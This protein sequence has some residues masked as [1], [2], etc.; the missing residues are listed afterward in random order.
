MRGRRTT[1]GAAVLALGFLGFAGGAPARADHADLEPGAGLA[2][3]F[4]EYGFPGRDRRAVRPV[5]DGVCECVGE[6]DRRCARMDPDGRDGTSG[7]PWVVMR[8][9]LLDEDPGV[10]WHR[11]ANCWFLGRWPVE[12]LVLGGHR[13]AGQESDERE[14]PLAL[15][16]ADAEVVPSSNEER[17]LRG[18]ERFR[19]GRMEPA[20]EDF[21]AAAT[22]D[23]AEPRARYGVLMCAFVAGRWKE[24]AEALRAL[25][26][27]GTLRPGDRIDTAVVFQDPDRMRSLI[28][29]LESYAKWSFHDD[30]AC[31]TLAWALLATGRVE[32]A[33][34]HLRAASRWNTD[35]P[36]V[37]ALCAPVSAA[38]PEEAPPADR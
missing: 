28:A 20:A 9:F 3:W 22:A 11:H 8:R 13:C 2:G 33:G 1:A 36:A 29:G 21:R 24:S 35:D 4:Q 14:C 7:T 32:Q 12:A 17:L 37:A 27:L 10:P 16:A 30:D 26:A 25:A 15:A 19:L 34:P 23:P 31:L 38:A 5:R 6:R 18:L